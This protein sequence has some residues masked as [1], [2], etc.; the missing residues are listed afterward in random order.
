[1]GG[2]RKAKV[3]T[4][5]SGKGKE[6]IQ[7]KWSGAQSREVQVSEENLILYFLSAHFLFLAKLSVSSLIHSLYFLNPTLCSGLCHLLLL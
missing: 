5:C 6:G 1:M 3:Y 2:G 4:E 7:E